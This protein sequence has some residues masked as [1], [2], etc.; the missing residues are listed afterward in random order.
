MEFLSAF[1]FCAS[2]KETTSFEAS[3]LFHPQS[4]IIHNSTPFVQHVGDNAN[5]NIGT[6]D[7]LGTFHA[8]GLIQCVIPATTIFSDGEIIRIPKNK[9]PKA[10]DIGQFD[11]P[12]K[13]FQKSSV[14]GLSTITVKDLNTINPVSNDVKLTSSDFFWLHSKSNNMSN[15]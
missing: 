11:V 2:Y 14:G 13:P 3:V 10:Y 12:L 8:M 9:I 15:I 4:T 7:G 6:I 1:G 5:V